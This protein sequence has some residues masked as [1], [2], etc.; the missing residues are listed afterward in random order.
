MFFCIALLIV[1]CSVLVFVVSRA[2]VSA[3]SAWLY[4][5]SLIQGTIFTLFVCKL[6]DDDD[7]YEIFESNRNCNL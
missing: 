4:L 1:W 7:E 3:V 2:T 6:N 5:L